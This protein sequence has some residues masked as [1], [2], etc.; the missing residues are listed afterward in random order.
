MKKLIILITF[1]MFAFTVSAQVS[2][3]FTPAS[4]D[5]LVGAVTKYCT[6]ASPITGQWT[7]NIEIYLTSSVG[8]DDSTWVSIEGSNDN[9]NWYT[10]DLGIPLLSGSAIKKYGIAAA[11]HRWTI[12]AASGG[13]MFCPTWYITPPYLRVKLQHY[14]A[15]TSVK[16]TRAK[17]Y[18]KKQ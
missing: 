18:L 6:L 11:T 9:T 4:N 7:A 14:V 2:L 12:A 17:I 13:L 1:A 15:A 3:N 10:I 5:S 16:V 8:A